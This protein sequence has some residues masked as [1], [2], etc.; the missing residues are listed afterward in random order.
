[1]TIFFSILWLLLAAF[2]AWF[3]QRQMRLHGIAVEMNKVIRYLAG[4][5]GEQAGAY[6]GVGVPSIAIASLAIMFHAS[7]AIAV[8]VGMRLML[9]LKQGWQ[10]RG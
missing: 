1:M 7:H 10:L 5:L 9:A 2:D 3:T 4:M 6:F 8:L